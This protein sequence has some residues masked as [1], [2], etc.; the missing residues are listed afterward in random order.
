MSARDAGQLAGR[1]TGRQLLHHRL[2]RATTPAHLLSS[3]C[4]GK[5]R[6]FGL[7][8]GSAYCA[9]AGQESAVRDTVRKR[10]PRLDATA[11]LFAQRTPLALITNDAEAGG[12]VG[13]F[14]MKA[15]RSEPCSVTCQ[16]DA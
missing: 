5:A 12:M 15:C 13:D 6:T 7:L 2:Q 9:W 8:T 14:S 4:T 1:H 16:D 3:E 11:S 10:Q